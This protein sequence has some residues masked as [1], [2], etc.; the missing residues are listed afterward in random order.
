MLPWVALGRRLHPELLVFRHWVEVL[1]ILSCL[2]VIGE[3]IDT[4]L[5]SGF[6]SFKVFVHGGNTVILTGLGWFWA[7]AIEVALLSAVKAFI[8][9]AVLRVG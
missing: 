9:G 2:C 4:V 6:L 7:F 8:S 1:I 5:F 3:L